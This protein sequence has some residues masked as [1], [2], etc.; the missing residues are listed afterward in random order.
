MWKTVALLLAAASALQA[1]PIRELVLD[2]RRAVD[3]PVSREVTTLVFPGPLTAVAGADLLIDDGKGPVEFEENP[4]LRFHVTHAPGG[5]F[6]LVQ[7]LRPDA[8]GRLTLMFEGAAYVVELHSVETDSV[9]SVIF[10]RDEPPTARRVDGPP[11]AV[12]FSPRIGLSLLD[13]ARAFP[14]LARVLPD[15][16]SDVTRSTPRR[17]TTLPDLEITVDEVYRFA[18]EDAVVFL[19][20]LRNTGDHPL[21]LAPETF[22]ARVG[23]E[24]FAHAIANGPVHLDPGE[25]APAEFAVIGMPDGTRNDLSAQNAFT[26]LINTAPAETA[27]AAN[28]ATPTTETP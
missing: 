13:R 5:S 9:A 20:R 4:A 16:V 6:V 22:A 3:L 19:L 28:A 23:Q 17:T 1:Q 15:A 21:A 12:R 2:P 24:R 18:R 11:A 26:I 7:S 8:V 14:V 10:G 25:S 27:V